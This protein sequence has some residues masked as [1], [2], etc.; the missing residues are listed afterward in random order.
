MVYRPPVAIYD[1]CV[2]YP[3]HL[4]NLLLQCAV[5][6]LVDARW[7]DE[8]HDEWMRSLLADRPALSRDDLTRTRG[9]MNRVLPEANVIGYQ[10][11]VEAV[12]LTDLDD[13]HVVAAAIE[14]NASLVVTWN[15][16]DFPLRELA[17]HGLR[18]Q[19]PDAL[20]MDLYEALPEIT[21]A[22]TASARTNLTRSGISAP[23]FVQILS[24]QGL[25]RF[26]QAI[27]AH[28]PAL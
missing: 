14:A 21:V 25:R 3:F 28:M 26:A 9:L 6:R 8:I 20:L 11:H 22:T 12:R 2:L 15:V 13:R 16:R 7:T 17:R 5:D 27:S 18:R 10:R 24:R 4:R 19:T 23:E 1:A